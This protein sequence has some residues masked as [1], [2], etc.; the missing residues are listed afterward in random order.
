MNG[1]G[2]FA[3]PKPTAA[4]PHA[5]RISFAQMISMLLMFSVSHIPPAWTAGKMASANREQWS[6]HHKATNNDRTIGRHAGS[7][8]H[9]R[10]YPTPEPAAADRHHVG[11]LAHHQEVLRAHGLLRER[12]SQQDPRRYLD[13]RRSLAQST[14]RPSLDQC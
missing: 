4:Y 9:W 7:P 3:F 6:R 11:Q 2:I 10:G 13:R 5:K 14:R 12:D 8:S 1:E